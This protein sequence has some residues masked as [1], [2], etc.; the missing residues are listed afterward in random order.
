VELWEKCP[1]TIISGSVQPPD[2][3]YILELDIFSDKFSLKVKTYSG[4][5]TTNNLDLM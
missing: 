3:Q 5:I 4:P 1:Y 2:N